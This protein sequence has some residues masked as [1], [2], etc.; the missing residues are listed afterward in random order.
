MNDKY[1]IQ[2][3]DYAG[4][5]D[6]KGINREQKPNP[7]NYSL[8]KNEKEVAELF[9]DTWNDYKATKAGSKNISNLKKS[10]IEDIQFGLKEIYQGP[11]FSK[12]IAKFSSMDLGSLKSVSLGL[13]GSVALGV[14][15]VIGAGCIFDI[16]DPLK[17]EG[18]VTGGGLFGIDADAELAE[19][20]GFWNCEY[21]EYGGKS[22]GVIL[23]GED[24]GGFT[25]G[26]FASS[27]NI[28]T[29][30]TGFSIGLAEGVGLEISACVTYTIQMDPLDSL[31]SVYQFPKSHFMIL[32]KLVCNHTS[33]DGAGD[34]DEVYFTFRADNDIE[35]YF[36]KTNYFSMKDSGDFDTWDCGRSVWF[37][38]SV[39]IIVYDQDD[40]S[41]D[42]VIGKGTINLSDLPSNGTEVSFDLLDKVDD[43]SSYTMYAK[44]VQTS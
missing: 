2:A 29:S 14:G 1:N 38:N 37:N 26:L 41:G 12:C 8:P 18:Y 44:L 24:V 11:A 28:L 22:F 21:D 15:V 27:L 25:V 23:A 32:T 9:Q 43:E 6:E 31:R 17:V 10:S 34:E 16:K 40:T 39:E 5:F 35:Y 42:D 33:P 36:P 20:A 4:M 13:S 3:T 7:V 30:I 19:E